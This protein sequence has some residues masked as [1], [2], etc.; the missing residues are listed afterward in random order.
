MFQ[1]FAITGG[2]IQL[3]SHII[4]QELGTECA[5]LMGANLAKEVAEE[6]FCETTIG[7]FTEYWFTSGQKLNTSNR[8]TSLLQTFLMLTAN[9]NVCS[10]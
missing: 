10:K 5:V 8:N 4:A 7:R 2:G 1:G 3:I 9:R 6:E